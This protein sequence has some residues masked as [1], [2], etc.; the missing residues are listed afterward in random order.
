MPEIVALIERLIDERPRLRGAT[1]T[2]TSRVDA[3]PDSYGALSGQTAGRAAGGGP[4]R[5]GR[6]QG[7]AA[8][9]RALEGRTSRT[10]TRWWDSPWGRGRPGWHIECSA[11]A[12]KHLGER[13]RRP[14]RRARPDLPAPRERA[15]AV[16]G[17]DAA[18]RSPARGSTT[19]CCG[20]RDEKMSKSLGNVERLRDALD[21]W[22]AETLLLLFARAHYRSPMDYTTDTLDAGR[23]AAATRLRE[24]LR[25][26]RARGRRRQRRRATCCDE[27][28]AARRRRF[29]AALDDDLATPRALAE[30]FG[31]DH[32][33]QPG[34]RRRGPLSQR[35]AAARRRRVP[36]AARRARPG[37]AR[38]ATTEV[39]AEVVALAEERAG[40]PR[41]PRLRPRRRA[42]RRDRGARLRRARRGRRF[43]LVPAAE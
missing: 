1:A 10:R 34:G 24:A 5:A 27:A 42:A 31:L 36:V 13:D 38:P 23:S 14:R 35:G 40:G 21:E 11:M 2:S 25:A 9:L 18:G 28:D 22:G 43:E 19:G 6:G 8:R 29:D 12:M 33:H 3:L 7:V 39:P 37:R 30:L 41:G 32:V 20:S 4:R 26:L 15:R 16:R 17:R